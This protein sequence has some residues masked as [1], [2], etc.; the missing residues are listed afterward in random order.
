MLW[1]IQKEVRKQYLKL[2]GPRMENADL[3][4]KS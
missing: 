4:Q 2:K 3:S 1:K